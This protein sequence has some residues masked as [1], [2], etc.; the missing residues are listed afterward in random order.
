MMAT[1]KT[2]PTDNQQ[3]SKQPVFDVAKPNATPAPA[4]S[5]P[6]IVNHRTMA[7]DPMMSSKAATEDE[8]SSEQQKLK[9]S[10]A[11]V[12]QPANDNVVPEETKEEGSKQ[13]ETNPSQAAEPTVSETT[14]KAVEEATVD[15]IA[16]QMGKKKKKPTEEDEVK[17]AEIKKHIEE[18]TFFVPIGQVKKRR[19]KRR[20]I[21]TI[22]FLLLLVAAYLVLDAD[23]FGLHVAV[24]IDLIK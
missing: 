19:N 13:K 21:A 20:L 3:P 9:V 6:I 5:R 2:E 10:K 12:I 18:K 16:S 24:P 4:T 11:K 17:Q 1:T 14:K 15:A 8:E 23:I 22:V 7:S